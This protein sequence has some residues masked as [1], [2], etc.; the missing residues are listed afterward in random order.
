MSTGGDQ[1]KL[2]AYFTLQAS[3]VQI[4]SP[5]IDQTLAPMTAIPARSPPTIGVSSNIKI[6]SRAPIPAGKIIAQ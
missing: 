1:S 4:N 6:A 2:L 5:S 3:A